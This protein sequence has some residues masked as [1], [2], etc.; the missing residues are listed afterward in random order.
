MSRF[1]AWMD[2]K[3]TVNA[4]VPVYK[5]II[6]SESSS[7]YHTD[8]QYVCILYNVMYIN[9]HLNK[10][11]K[12]LKSRLY[13]WKDAC[14][15]FCAC[16]RF[17]NLVVIFVRGWT[18]W[19]SLSLSLSHT[20][21]HI[22]YIYIY[23][24]IYKTVKESNVLSPSFPRTD[25]VLSYV[26]LKFNEGLRMCTTFNVGSPP[27]PWISGLFSGGRAAG[28]WRWPPTPYLAPWLKSGSRRLITFCAFMPSSR[29]IF[30]FIYPIHWY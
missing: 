18:A 2:L 7:K 16:N 23:I 5:E 17:R 14:C 20:H 26:Q 28:A 1:N 9:A 29:A 13:S 4:Y 22:I 10:F 6:Q 19:H 21:T 30:T 15:S 11:L 24:Y 3:V 25:F 12:L 27:V 8:T